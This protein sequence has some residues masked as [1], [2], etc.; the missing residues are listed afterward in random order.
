MT[1]EAIG[2]LALSFTLLIHLAGTIWW[3]ATL[4]RRVEHIEQWINKNELSGE[5]LAAVEGRLHVACSCL[6]KIESTLMEKS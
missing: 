4:T 1:A 6:E 3:A 2:L 5:R